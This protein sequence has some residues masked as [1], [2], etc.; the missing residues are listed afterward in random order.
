MKTM[1]CEQPPAALRLSPFSRRTMEPPNSTPLFSPLGVAHTTARQFAHA[2]ANA[3]DRL[4]RMRVPSDPRTTFNV[5]VVSGGT[6][7]HSIPNEVSMEVDMRS[8]SAEE[9][10]KE[11][12]TFLGWMHDAVGEENHPDPSLREELSWR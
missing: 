5:G 10:A 6:S 1:V 9:L 3:I 12:E 7:V 8:E 11:A 2:M 4:S